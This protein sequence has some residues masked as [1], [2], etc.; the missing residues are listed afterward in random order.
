[1]GRN[2]PCQRLVTQWARTLWAGTFVAKGLS[3]SGLEHYGQ[4]L[5]LVKS[6]SLSGLDHYGQEHSLPK[7]CRSVG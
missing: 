6:L 7:A 5:F 3:L 2:F 1:M 4:E